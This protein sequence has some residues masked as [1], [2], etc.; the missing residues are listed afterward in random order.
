MREHCLIFI[1]QNYFV[2]AWPNRKD[3]SEEHPKTSSSRDSGRYMCREKN[4]EEIKTKGQ[5]KKQ[6]P[7]YGLP[8]H[9][10]SPHAKKLAGQTDAQYI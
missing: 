1:T 10:C 5:E 9:D 3:I 2:D 4:N 8:S 6:N 7:M